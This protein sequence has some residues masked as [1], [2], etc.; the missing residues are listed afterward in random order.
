MNHPHKE[1]LH[2]RKN[3]VHLFINSECCQ[4]KDLRSFL[5]IFSSTPSINNEQMNYVLSCKPV[6]VTSCSNSTMCYLNLW[7]KCL[8]QMTPFL[9]TKVN[10]GFWCLQASRIL[11]TSKW[12]AGVWLSQEKQLREDCQWTVPPKMK[13]L[14]HTIT[15]RRSP[16]VLTTAV[17]FSSKNIWM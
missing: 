7:L 5:G 10:L 12:N 11:E 6:V 9:M 8:S 2:C 15:R 1:H 14:L 4:R 3:L 17:K 16:S 13:R